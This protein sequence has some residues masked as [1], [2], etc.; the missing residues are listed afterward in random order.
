M[1]RALSVHIESKRATQRR[2][3]PET[4]LY[5]SQ[6]KSAAPKVKALTEKVAALLPEYC[7]GGVDPV[8]VLLPP[9]AVPLVTNVQLPPGTL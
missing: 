9:V 8:V 1:H 5:T 6:A 2:Q 7:A 4:L 3:R